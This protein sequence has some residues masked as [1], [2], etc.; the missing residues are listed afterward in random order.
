VVRN[1]TARPGDLLVLTKPLGTGIIATALKA[2]MAPEEVAA[3]AVRW[4]TTLNAEAS[5]IMVECEAHAC[6]DVTG[7]GLLGHAFEMARGSGVTTRLNRVQIPVMPGVYDLAGDGLVP[8]GCY[9]NRDHFEAY[10]DSSHARDSLLLPFFDP[11]TSGGLLIALSPE[12]AEKFLNLARDRG[13]F[14]ACIGDV[15]Y[16]RER[17]VEFFP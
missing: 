17:H 3:E 15:D 16:L 7:F 2:D 9:R 13:C 5:A 6:T 8:A 4:M 10:L 14:A 1:S 12:S 11:Q